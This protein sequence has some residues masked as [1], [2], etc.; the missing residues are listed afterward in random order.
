V[1]GTTK[2]LAADG[3]LVSKTDECRPTN[4]Y[5]DGYDYVIEWLCS[6]NL[7][8]N[9][10][11]KC[12][13]GCKDGACLS[14][15]NVTMKNECQDVYAFACRDSCFSNE[16]QARYSCP[17]GICC[18]PKFTVTCT[19][20]SDCQKQECNGIFVKDMLSRVGKCEYGK[21]WSC[22]DNFDNDGD[23]LVD[24]ED[25]D[26]PIFK[27][28][29]LT[30]YVIQHDIAYTD[31][32]GAY[33]YVAGSAGPGADWIGEIVRENEGYSAEYK[34][35]DGCEIKAFVFEFNPES[36]SQQNLERSIKEEFCQYFDACYKTLFEDVLVYSF[37]NPKS[38]EETKIKYGA[39][40]VSYNKIILI[41]AYSCNLPQKAC[42]TSIG[43]VSKYLGIFPVSLEEEEMICPLIVAWRIE[44]DKCISDA[45]CDYSPE[46]YKYYN[47]PEECNSQ[48]EKC[49]PEWNCKLEPLECPSTGIQTKIC[50]DTRCLLGRSEEDIAC[51]T[52]ECSGC[53]YGLTCL[54]FG[55]KLKIDDTTPSYCSINKIFEK[56]KGLGEE[57]QNDHECLSDDC[58]DGKCISTY[59]LLQAILDFLNK[60]FG[61]K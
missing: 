13:N 37:S 29:T 50:T 14:S 16:E 30:K 6:N 35:K 21:E 3:V 18:K 26:C 31:E 4:F 55:Y 11:E 46:K 33:K 42:L 15:D 38:S 49:I 12:P 52:G 23:G 17:R 10:N 41:A 24:T 43:M 7:V 9:T 51:K 56:Q 59:S 44:K 54:P 22:N 60:I 39:A 20:N 8:I 25:Y 48:L 34:C 57:C 28:E 19:T 36:N 1:K 2:G 47:S 45:G 58:S 53:M 40:W 27:N 5:G 61:G 32:D